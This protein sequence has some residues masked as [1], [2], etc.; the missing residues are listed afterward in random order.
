MYLLLRIAPVALWGGKPVPV[1]KPGQEAWESMNGLLGAADRQQWT[2]SADLAL[3][4]RP[5][6]AAPAWLLG[7][8]PPSGLWAP[9][10]AVSWALGCLWRIFQAA[11][12]DFMVVCLKHIL[13]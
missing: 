8:P 4:R 3:D 11:D 2:P 5:G 6:L 13:C 7:W 9:W 12:C 10:P 1:W